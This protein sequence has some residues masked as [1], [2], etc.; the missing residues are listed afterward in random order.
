MD[1]D[2]IEVF[3]KVVQAGS[4][5]NAARLLNMPKTTVSAKLAALEKRL[6]TSLIY[7]TTRKLHVTEAGEKYFH[8]CANAVREMELG[9]AALQ[10]SQGTPTGLLKVT[11]PVDIGHAV[12]PHVT[13]AY[14]AKYPD[15]TIELLISNQIADLV[16]GG[17][18]L[19]IRA[20]ML[21]DS[22]LIAK[23][24][25][26]LRANLWASP[27]YIKEFRKFT[28][29]KDLVMASFVG[30]KGV[31]VLR[32][33]DGKSEVDVPV[34]SRVIADDLETIK[35]LTILGEGVGWLPDFLSAD[36]VDAG[37]LVPVLPQWKWKGGGA[38]YFVY[39]GQKY[40][41]PKVQAFIQTALDVVSSGMPNFS[42]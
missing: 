40:A 13:R 32:L 33:T 20:G 42:F 4:L 6:G 11:A 27:S 2:A 3:V 8:H 21:K 39:A 28:H 30:R 31:D 24:F 35:A 14:L 1:L 41:S 9:E 17:V 16:G 12:L 7:R 5:S 23:R 10:S 26:D 38:F 18:D 29:P 15:V 34:V 19:A 25:I 22:S 36:A 37:T